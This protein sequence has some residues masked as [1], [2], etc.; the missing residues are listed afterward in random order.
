MEI[1]SSSKRKRLASH[2]NIHP[3]VCIPHLVTALAKSKYKHMKH[4]LQS[5]LG[6]TFNSF[7]YLL[8]FIRNIGWECLVIFHDRHI[9]P[10]LIAE[11]YSYMISNKDDTGLLVSITTCIQGVKY[12]IDE[13]LI[14]DALQLRKSMLDLPKINGYLY[15]IGYS[16]TGCMSF[17]QNLAITTDQIIPAN[18][19]DFPVKIGLEFLTAQCQFLGKILRQ[20]FMP[21]RE[22][23]TLFPCKLLEMINI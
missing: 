7:P 6:I 14:I 11:F 18:L 21:A 22:D 20:N 8:E 9:Y 3:D 19:F 17:K 23:R 2:S 5:G 1:V 12:T 13:Q 16:A 4:N 15:L 10:G